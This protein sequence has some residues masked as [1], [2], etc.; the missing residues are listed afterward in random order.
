M[1]TKKQVKFWSGV[2]SK[3]LVFGVKP[4]CAIL[5]IPSVLTGTKVPKFLWILRFANISSV[6]KVARMLRV[7]SVPMISRLS[8]VPKVPNVRKL[9]KV[10]M[11]LYNPQIPGIT[12]FP[13]VS[14]VPRIS[15]ASRI[16]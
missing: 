6:P 7:P 14:S 8:R 12:R 2:G 13:R 3:S 1:L 5:R 10:P 11:I 15:R 16:P 9:S 4:A